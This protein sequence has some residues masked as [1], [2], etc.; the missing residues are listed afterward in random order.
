[1]ALRIPAFFAELSEMPLLVPQIAASIYRFSSGILQRTKDSLL[2][3]LSEIGICQLADH[4]NLV[5]SSRVPLQ[6]SLEEEYTCTGA[7]M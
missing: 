4:S 1:M 5:M 3:F 6:R 2:A 7:I